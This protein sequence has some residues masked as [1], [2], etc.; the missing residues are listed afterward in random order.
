VLQ[1]QGPG[2]T[3]TWTSE[4]SFKGN[5]WE[6]PTAKSGKIYLSTDQ[7]GNPHVSTKKLCMVERAAAGGG[8]FSKL[9]F[10]EAIAMELPSIAHEDF[11]SPFQDGTQ[12]SG[13]VATEVTGA[14]QTTGATPDS[15]ESDRR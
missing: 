6:A 1:E 2:D 14:A 12:W 7:N 15:S 10:D 8:S 11:P 13:D 5:L 3:Y 9:A 4:I